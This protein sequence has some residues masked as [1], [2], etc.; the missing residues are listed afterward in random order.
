[1]FNNVVGRDG[2]K[3]LWERW[4]LAQHQRLAKNTALSLNSHHCL[5]Y[6]QTQLNISKMMTC[7]LNGFQLFNYRFGVTLLK[8]AGTK[9]KLI[10]GTMYVK[11][12]L[13]WLSLKLL[14]KQ[15]KRKKHKCIHISFGFR[16]FHS[17]VKC[18]REVHGAYLKFI[19]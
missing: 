5:L 9:Y 6:T 3:Y 7:S 1:M 19:Q 8:N 4:G 16:H 17:S 11:Q 18:Q 15:K 13:K 14:Q 12:I 10:M 2:G